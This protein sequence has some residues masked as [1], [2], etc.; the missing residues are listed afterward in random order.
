MRYLSGY[1]RTQPISGMG[2]LGEVRQGVDGNLYQWVQGVDGLGNP[3]GFWKKLKKWGKRLAKTALK[4]YPPAA[5]LRSLVPLA[6]RAL[7][8]IQRAMASQPAAAV[9]V[10]PVTPV[11]PAEAPAEAAPAPA[12]TAGWGLGALLQGPDG[13][14]YQVQGW[15]EADDLRGFAEDE[16]RGF[17]EADDLR[18][19]GALYQ[20]PDGTMYRVQ[21]LAEPDDLRGFAEDELRGLD[22]P[23]DLRG[24]AEDDLRGFEEADDLRGFA[25]DDLRGFEEADDLRGFA[26]DELRGFEEADD[27]RGFAEDDLRG[28]E[29]ADDLRGLEAYVSDKPA[30]TRWFT[31]PAQTP[32]MWRPLW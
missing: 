7:P 8:Y 2:Y 12:G 32:E 4:Y 5:A 17:E 9:P 10:V 19:L 15:G 25:E 24:F 30:G 1:Q 21:G 18:G 28:F 16:L 23:D 11:M 3:I 22:E 20:A 31:P 27:L 26:E 13:T 29:E 6:S 14:L